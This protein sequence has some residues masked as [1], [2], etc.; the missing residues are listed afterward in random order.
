MRLGLG[1]WVEE[2]SFGYRKTSIKCLV[3]NKRWVSNKRRGSEARVLINTGS[4][5]NTGSQIAI[6]SYQSTGHTI[7]Q[8]TLSAAA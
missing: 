8:S 3:L 4:R 6:Q 7:V 2:P 5:L 1:G